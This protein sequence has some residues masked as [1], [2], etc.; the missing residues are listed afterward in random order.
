MAYFKSFGIR[1]AGVYGAVPQ[2]RIPLENFIGQFPEAI[3]NR[4]IERTGIT[5]VY[6]SPSEQTASDLGYAAAECLLEKLHVDRNDIGILLFSTQSPDYIKPATACVLQKRLNL[7][8]QCAAF[9]VSLGCSAFVY[10][11]QLIQAMMM[12]GTARYGLLI[13][14]ET[15]SRLVSPQDKSIAMMFGDAGAAVLYEKMGTGE[16]CTLLMSDGNRYKTIIVPAGGFRDRHPEEEY[17]IGPDGKKRSK[18]CEYMDGIE[19]FSFSVTDVVN[20]IQEYLETFNRNISEYDYVVLH[21][22]NQQILNRISYKLNIPV[23]KILISL[24][25]YGNTSG[26]SI[27]LTIAKELGGLKEGK[28]RILAVGYGIG[29]SWGITEMTVE[30]NSIFP[31]I[32]T[33][34]CYKEG[35]VK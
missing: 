32:E 30:C 5:S 28:K 14:A 3:V 2:A 23:Q 33:N 8:T 27:P 34:E 4:F 11:N 16:T 20:S 22:A 35:I 24:D 9:D 6:R 26:V 29:L 1:T 7:S 10:C 31:V 15:S 18:Y 19:V 21:Q 13:I 25:E 12:A 17:Y